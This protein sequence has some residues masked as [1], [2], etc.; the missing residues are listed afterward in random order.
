VSR[1][2]GHQQAPQGAAPP[3]PPPLPRY[4]GR[5]LSFSPRYARPPHLVQLADDVEPHVREGV[6][7]QRQEHRQQVV[8]RR[9]LAQ[10]RR[11]LHHDAR[12]RGAHKL[13]AVVGKVLDAW[14]DLG[15][16]V[17]VGD[18]GGEGVREGASA[19]ACAAAQRRVQGGRA[20]GPP[21][22]SLRHR[23]G[24]QPCARTSPLIPRIPRRPT[25]P[26]MISGVSILQNAATLPAAAMRTSASGSRRRLTNAE[27]R[28]DLAGK[29][30]GRRGA[31]RARERPAAAAA[32]PAA[33]RPQALC[34][35]APRPR[36]TSPLAHAQPPPPSPP[37]RPHRVRSGPSASHSATSCCAAL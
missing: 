7:Q 21:R 4:G 35:G 1:R 6:L 34:V 30:D 29:G 37:R 16:G 27:V 3:A 10:L 5:P 2:C 25:W 24:P 13:A 18:L 17:G 14:R 32:D 12:E 26:M 22:L 15:G 31:S 33:A 11:E 19:G 20:R 28:S 8:D 36:P 9:L 23:L